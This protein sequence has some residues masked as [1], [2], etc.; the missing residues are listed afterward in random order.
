[1]RKDQK[2]YSGLRQRLLTSFYDTFFLLIC[3]L[4]GV[5]D[6]DWLTCPI[7]VKPGASVR[8]CGSKRTCRSP[9]MCV[10]VLNSQLMPKS[11]C[12]PQSINL[13]QHSPCP[14]SDRIV[15]VTSSSFLGHTLDIPSKDP[16]HSGPVPNG[17]PLNPPSWVD[18]YIQHIISFVITWRKYA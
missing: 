9:C 11:F 13:C 16:I 5:I 10:Y 8:V 12:A 4:T 18:K 7:R 14:P 1:M 6:T 15:D 2:I 3:L 17:P